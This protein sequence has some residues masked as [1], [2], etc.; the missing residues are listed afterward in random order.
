VS[1]GA[2]FANRPPLVSDYRA[3][4]ALWE[5]TTYQG[6]IEPVTYWTSNPG[7]G[8]NW[9]DLTQVTP[10]D[11]GF[12]DTVLPGWPLGPRSVFIKD[13]GDWYSNYQY[14]DISG[15]GFPTHNVPVCYG[16][17]YQLGPYLSSQLGPH[18]IYVCWGTGPGLG[19]GSPPGPPGT[20]TVN[21]LS[22][23]LLTSPAHSYAG[24]ALLPWVCAQT[25]VVLLAEMAHS[26]P[27]IFDA[28]FDTEA[29][30]HRANVKPC[31]GRFKGLVTAE[32]LRVAELEPDYA[33]EEVA[34]QAARDANLPYLK[35]QAASVADLG[36]EYMTCVKADVLQALKDFFG[37]D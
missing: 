14:N 31:L 16:E 19:P 9:T 1:L 7:Y 32:Y 29:A 30:W 28:D 11:S 8:V 2:R 5:P 17:A 23:W 6:L 35:D 34:N 27:E 33:G 13:I 37:I 20:T 15:V 4:P 24:T 21:W 10:G 36:W 3:Q 26:Q 12:T 22:S 18:G 25:A